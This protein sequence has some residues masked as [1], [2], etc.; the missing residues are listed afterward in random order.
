MK[1]PHTSGAIAP[2]NMNHLRRGVH[3]HATTAHGC[4][5]GEYL[6]M[7]SLFGDRA[8]LLR[9]RTGTASITVGDVESILP[10]AA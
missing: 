3:Y 6:G 7:E 9:H 1:A 8:I 4:T 2:Q 5:S 10:I